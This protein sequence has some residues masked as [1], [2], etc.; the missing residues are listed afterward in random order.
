MRDYEKNDRADQNKLQKAERASFSDSVLGRTVEDNHK[1]RV[2]LDKFSSETLKKAENH[3][4]DS[5]NPLYESIRTLRNAHTAEEW[6]KERT[7]RRQYDTAKAKLALSKI[8]EALHGG[9]IAPDSPLEILRNEL[10]QGDSTLSQMSVQ[11]Y[12]TIDSIS[13]INEEKSESIIYNDKKSEIPKIQQQP[14]T[15]KDLPTKDINDEKSRITKSIQIEIAN[16]INMRINDKI[17]SKNQERIINNNTSE[18]ITTEDI[19][20]AIIDVAKEQLPIQSDTITAQDQNKKLADKIRYTIASQMIHNDEL[21]SSLAK[22]VVNKFKEYGHID[23]NDDMNSFADGVVFYM[24]ERIHQTTAR[25]SSTSASEIPQ[26]IQ[27]DTTASSFTNSQF[28]DQTH[29]YQRRILDTTVSSSS[30]SNSDISQNMQYQDNA[31]TNTERDTALGELSTF[32]RKVS[33]KYSEK[34]NFDMRYI[35]LT[36]K[37]YYK[38][39]EETPRSYN[40]TEKFWE[41]QKKLALGKL[42]KLRRE[43]NSTNPLFQELDQLI[44]TLEFPTQK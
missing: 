12:N 6:N 8:K 22:K 29:E 19:A 1:F 26:S 33:S 15:S 36:M 3:L 5:N 32:Y 30:D 42:E 25:S 14:D 35:S 10:L 24:N 9:P 11:D 39:K 37:D 43:G 17:T 18:T 20:N 13:I 2:T 38:V 27:Q 41:D 40:T 28:I 16:Q 34:I 7:P 44:K 4:K 31:A 21:K 23:D